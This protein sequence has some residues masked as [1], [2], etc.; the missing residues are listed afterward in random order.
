MPENIEISAKLKLDTTEAEDKIK[1][2]SK[3]GKGAPVSL[4]KDTKIQLPKETT[5]S[6]KEAFSGPKGLGQIGKLMKGAS[7][8]I[9]GLSGALSDMSQSLGAMG[10]AIMIAVAAIGILIKLLQGT[11]T[12]DAMMKSVNSLMNVLRDSL[13]P[14]LAIIGE[15]F[16]VLVDVIKELAPVLNLLVQPLNMMLQPFMFLVKLLEPIAK[17]LGAVINVLVEIQS[18]FTDLWSGVL[19]SIFDTILQ[20]IDEALKPLLEWIDKVIQFFENLKEKIQ[21]FITSITGGLIKFNKTS[22]ASTTGKKAA[23]G[24]KT[25]LD[26]WQTSGGEKATEK[27]ARLAA[28]A[29]DSAAQAS[30]STLE[31]TTSLGDFVQ[32]MP[33]SILGIAKNAWTAIEDYAKT[34]WSTVK[35]VAS[36]VWSDIRTFASQTWSDVKSVASDVYS[37]IKTVASDVWGEFKASASSVWQE[38]KPFALDLWTGMKGIVEDTWSG[39]TTVA[40]NVWDGVVEATS[41]A[42]DWV[43]E[44]ASTVGNWFSDA[45]NTVKGWF[46]G[47]FAD[48]GTIDGEIWGMNERG[49]PEFLFGSGGST[50]VVNAEMLSEAM[51]NALVRANVGGSQ[52]LEV[53]VKEGTPA[54]PRELAQWL[55]PSL[56]Y[57]LH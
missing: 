52:R 23:N 50:T 16:I 15:V 42:W 56:K 21:D 33:E 36:T 45:A 2:M 39:V 34:A 31:S 32:G 46:S 8:G 44:G 22:L 20:L 9:N 26:V 17:I 10:G 27:S 37:G 35:D 1:Q 38:V 40:G 55:L 57:V 28:E 4:P 49:N 5:K 41:T 51:Y 47:W 43:E 11:D 13:A 7:G 14:L 3:S 48:G 25:S 54:G 12:W 18:I 30:K 6:L 29:A 19:T 53:S 24:I